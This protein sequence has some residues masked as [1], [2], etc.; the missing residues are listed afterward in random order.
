[1]QTRMSYLRE[2]KAYAATALMLST[3]CHTRAIRSMMQ[4][5][6]AEYMVEYYLKSRTF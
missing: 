2:L 6:A 3:Q 1:M 4:Q 5:D